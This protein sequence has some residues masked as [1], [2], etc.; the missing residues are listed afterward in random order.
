MYTIYIYFNI[1]TVEYLQ[2]YIRNTITFVLFNILMFFFFH[3]KLVG[4]YL[5]NYNCIKT[6]LKRVIQNIHYV[7][8]IFIKC[9]E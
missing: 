1:I 7:N 3:K 5:K 9:Q 2:D 6:F 4:T 8:L